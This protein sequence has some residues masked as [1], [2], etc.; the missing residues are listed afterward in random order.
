MDGGQEN[1]MLTGHVFVFFAITSTSLGLVIYKKWAKNKLKMTL[2]TAIILMLFAPVF[3]FIALKYL[4]ID[5][6]YMATSLNG[7]V[8]LFLSRYLLN[9]DV[10][11]EQL[12]GALLVFFGVCVYMI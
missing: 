10:R 9:E 1:K 4:S 11:H 6:V 8:V 5:V 2:L 3:N 12:I 7:L